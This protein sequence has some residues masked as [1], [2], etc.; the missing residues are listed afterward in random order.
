[1]LIGIGHA[2]QERLLKGAPVQHQSNEERI[3]HAMADV[4]HGS[5]QDNTRYR[6]TGASVLCKDTR[7]LLDLMGDCQ[8][9]R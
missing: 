2:I 1:L 7:D 6:P 4:Q 3:S 9:Q 8:G 5:L